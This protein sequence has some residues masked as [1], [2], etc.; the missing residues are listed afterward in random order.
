M[1]GKVMDSIQNT[2][3]A[4]SGSL[5]IAVFLF[6]MTNIVCRNLGGI[7]IRWIP[8]MIR[9]SFI[10]SVLLATAV[11]YRRDDHLMVDYF[12]QKMGGKLRKTVRTVTDLLTLPFFSLVIIYGFRITR[13][14]MRISYETWNFPTGYAYL[15]LPV[16]A[17][18]M[19]VFNFER[20]F[21]FWKGRKR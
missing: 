19:I 8:G 1:I 3:E 13:V 11:L 20:L 16:A 21:S 17:I 9:L 5:F 18:L 10:W 2:L 14:R 12:V 15:A 4:L 7:A 6:T